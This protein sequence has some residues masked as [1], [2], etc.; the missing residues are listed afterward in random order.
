MQNWI[1]EFPVAFFLL[2]FFQ[3]LDYFLTFFFV[4]ELVGDSRGRAANQTAN[5]SAN[6]SSNNRNG[7]EGLANHCSRNGGSNRS[8]SS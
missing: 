3:I 4:V 7:N 1:A 6:Q 2:H 8:A 5:N